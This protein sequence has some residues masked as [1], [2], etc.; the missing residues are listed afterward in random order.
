LGT[1]AAQLDE[2]F[3]HR[4]ERLV[5]K[6]G[7]V[8]YEGRLFEVPYEL[9]DKW[10]QLVVDPHTETAVSVEDQEGKPLGA[11]TPL[12]ALAN[13]HRKRNKPR[14]AAPAAQGAL[15][16]AVKRATPTIVELACRAHYQPIASSAKKADGADEFTAK[17]L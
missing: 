2:L 1:L 4:V 13:R 7:T 17:G 14:P 3:Y 6:D 5:R 12:D 8:S 11:V 10:V 15:D 9:V 16:F